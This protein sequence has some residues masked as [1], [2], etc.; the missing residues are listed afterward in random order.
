MNKGASDIRPLVVYDS[1]QE[2]S[3][4]LSR[5]IKA[6]ARTRGELCI[7][8]AGCGNSWQMDLGG[9]RY[10]LTGVD[11]NQD[12]LNIRKHEGDLQ[13]AVLGDLR[14]VYLEENRFDVIYNSFVLEHIENAEL[15][16]NNFHRW[17]RPG[18]ILILRIPDPESVYGF[19]SKA[20]PF[21][22]HVFYKRYIGGHKMAGKP[23]YDPFPTVYN[24]IVSPRGFTVGVRKKK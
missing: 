6:I 21:W 18:G 24:P 3:Q 19:L 12:A 22:L 8:D 5:Y 7:L 23:G 4:R 14:T 11:L 15:V 10:A 2:E 16:L 13:E 20:T 1:P 9:V 17:L